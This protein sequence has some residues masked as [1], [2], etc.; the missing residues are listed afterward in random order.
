MATLFIAFL[1]LMVV[2]VVAHFPLAKYDR[3]S[4]YT[5][6]ALGYTDYPVLESAICA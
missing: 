3:G 2:V 1:A 4:F 5:F 6:G